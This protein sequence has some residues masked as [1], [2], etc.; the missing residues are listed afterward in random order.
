MV[1]VEATSTLCSVVVVAAELCKTDVVKEASIEEEG[2]KWKINTRAR[3]N[4]A[5]VAPSRI[6]LARASAAPLPPASHLEFIQLTST[7]DG[8]E[9]S[10]PSA[11]G[12]FK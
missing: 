11:G 4:P 9:S 7:D 2:E 12:A 8:V 5:K 3:Y 6:Y 1:V 10:S